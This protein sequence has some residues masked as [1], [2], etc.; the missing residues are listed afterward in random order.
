M[1]NDES[2]DRMTGEPETHTLDLGV[3]DTF[4][5]GEWADIED[6]AGRTVVGADLRRPPM[7]LLAGILW[8]VRRREDPRATYADAREVRFTAVALERRANPTP[9]AGTD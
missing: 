5:L 6:A 8:I 9:A 2:G 4:T 1:T 3:V 7:W